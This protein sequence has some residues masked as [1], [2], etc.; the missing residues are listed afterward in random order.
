MPGRQHRTIIGPTLQQ[1]RPDEK[2]GVPPRKVDAEIVRTPLLSRRGHHG[3]LL[4]G[5]VAAPDEQDQEADH[6]RGTHD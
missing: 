4:A 2:T 1:H 6:Q 5:V 3:L